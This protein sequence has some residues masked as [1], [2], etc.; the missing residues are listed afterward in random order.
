MG[1]EKLNEKR[2]RAE[3]ATSALSKPFK[4]P[5]RR[6]AQTTEAKDASSPTITKHISSSAHQ[7]KEAHSAEKIQ[8]QPATSTTIAS[9]API[10]SPS[11]STLSP[12]G[13]G[14]RK[15]KNPA[16][17]LTP[18]K[19]PV[20]LDPEITELQ[21]QQRALQSRLS[22]LRSELDTAQQALRVES[23]DKDT[24]LEKLIA[25]WKTASQD[26]AEE[27]FAG[28][29]E[30]VARLGGMKAWKEQMRNN[31]TRWEQ[32]EMNSWYGSGDAEG[33]DVD[34][35]ELESRKAEMLEQWDVPGKEVEGKKREDSIE[36]EEFTMD[37][38]LKTLN[39][40]LKLIGYD[41][42]SQRWVK[43]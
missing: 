39:V 41:K 19:K 7:I 9:N 16:S 18:T 14:S 15:R 20:L 38:M 32:E 22:A 42:E 35:E 29:Q 36:E 40:D 3:H 1:S 4:S 37:F 2:R 8:E 17:Y 27:V 6:P 25:K 24:E 28:A 21:K 43:D 13:L 12:L 34:E 33:V 5:L 11:S 23:S 31:S 26:A 30:R 10:N